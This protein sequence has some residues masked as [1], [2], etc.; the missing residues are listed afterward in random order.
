[1]PKH[2]AS[3][4]HLL[5]S[6]CNNQQEFGSVGAKDEIKMVYMHSKM[7]AVQTATG[8]ELKVT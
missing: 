5:L 3:R 6:P 8:Y 2:L 1:M 7:K 4:V